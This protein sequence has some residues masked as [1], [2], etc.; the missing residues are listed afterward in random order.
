MKRSSPSLPP[1][2]DSLPG[3]VRKRIRTDRL[4]CKHYYRV[5]WPHAVRDTLK[6]RLGALARSLA[7]AESEREMVMRQHI[8]V[9]V[10]EVMETVA[11]L[12]RKSWPETPLPDHPS[13]DDVRTI[14]D[15]LDAMD[16][17][18]LDVMQTFLVKYAPWFRWLRHYIGHMPCMMCGTPPRNQP[19]LDTPPEIRDILQK[20][21]AATELRRLAMMPAAPTSPQNHVLSGIKPPLRLKTPRDRVLSV[22]L[23][24]CKDLPMDVAMSI[25]SDALDDGVLDGRSI[26]ERAK[27]DTALQPPESPVERDNPPLADMPGVVPPYPEVDEQWLEEVATSLFVDD[28]DDDGVSVVSL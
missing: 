21:R 27:G 5:G 3:P 6:H 18:R 20:K 23:R 1:V 7:R 15:Q 8:R 4:V 25:F 10:D 9:A 12:L 24:S 11:E 2:L 26:L 19:P 17:N 22:L 28:D 14:A 16:T 13:F